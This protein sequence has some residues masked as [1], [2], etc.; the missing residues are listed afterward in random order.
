MKTTKNPFHTLGLLPRFKR[1]NIN[2]KE[3]R[4]YIV[5]QNR[6][7]GILYHPQNG[8]F[9]NPVVLKQYTEAMADVKR[10][11]DAQLLNWVQELPNITAPPFGSELRILAE[12]MLESTI[13][14]LETQVEVQEAA[15]YKVRRRAKLY[16]GVG[17]LV[18]LIAGYICWYQ[19]T[20]EAP[21]KHQPITIGKLIKPEEEQTYINLS[22]EYRL[23]K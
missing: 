11:S 14:R 13:H 3:I 19:S 9:P 4:E 10:A 22:R 21:K 18:G 8:I 17:V 23:N 5:T 6:G 16:F 2:P 1:P 15:L 12:S 20:Q 7:V